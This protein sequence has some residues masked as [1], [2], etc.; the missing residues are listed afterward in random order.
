[1]LLLLSCEK[2]HLTIEE[3]MTLKCGDS[4]TWVYQNELQYTQLIVKIMPMNASQGDPNTTMWWHYQGT[5]KSTSYDGGN[6]NCYLYHKY[7]AYALI[8]GHHP[9]TIGDFVFYE[10]GEVR[11]VNI[12]D[13]VSWN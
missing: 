1:M 12:L 11:K 2:E 5:F 10:E 13:G 4:I 6:Y 9:G 7:E 8:D 3:K